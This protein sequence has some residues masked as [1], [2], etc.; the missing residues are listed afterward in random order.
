MGFTGF[1]QIG[2]KKWKIRVAKTE[3]KTKRRTHFFQKK[4]FFP[5]RS[6]NRKGKEKESEGRKKRKKKKEKYQ[7][8][9][10]KIKNKEKNSVTC[11]ELMVLI[12]NST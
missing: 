7:K 2:K 4:F 6:H 1:Y 3:K 10:I 8:N 9:Q 11:T 5:F 12:E